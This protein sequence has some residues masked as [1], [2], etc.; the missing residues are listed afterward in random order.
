MVEAGKS[1]KARFRE[2]TCRALKATIKG[3]IFYTIYF[4]IST[5]LTPIS[6]V[7]PGFQQIIETFVMVYIFLIVVSEIVSGTIFQ[8]LFNIT[9]A[10]FVIIYLILSLKGG[11]VSTT[12]QNVKLT[13]DLRLFLMA[14]TLLGLLGLAKSTFQ[15]IN[16]L[17][18]R[19]EPSRI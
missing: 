12:F 17:N 8:H 5:F 11:T 4:V 10:F 16:F 7:I 1:V 2:V 9:K 6:D 3:T 13:L 15:A 14:A 19:A 18:E